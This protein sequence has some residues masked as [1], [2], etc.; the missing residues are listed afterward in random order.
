MASVETIS[1]PTGGWNARDAYA[2]MRPDHAVVLDNWFPSEG[3]VELRKGS[4]EHATTLGGWVQT[5]AE[6]HNGTTNKFLAAANNNIWDIT[7]AGAGSSLASGFTNDQWDTVMMDAKMGFVNGADAPQEYDGST[8]SAMTI[9][10]SGLTVANL[11]GVHVHGRRSYFWEDNSQDVWYSALNTLGGTLTKFQLSRVANRGGELLRMISWTRDGGDGPDDYAVF[12]MSSGE[13][14]VYRGT[15]PGNAA[16]FSI[17]GRYQIG[18]P[19]GRRCA[20]NF[21]GDVIVITKEGYVP[22]SQ[23]LGSPI[24]TAISDQISNAVK[25]HAKNHS[26]NFGWQ[27]IFFAEEGMAIFN[28]PTSSTMSVQHVFNTNTGA[29]CRFTGWNT[30]CFG[31]FQGSLYFGGNASVYQAWDGTSDDGTAIEA[32]AIPAFLP[33]GKGRITQ[34]SALQPVFISNGE[35]DVSIESR[36]DFDIGARPSTTLATG[37]AAADWDTATWDVDD[38]DTREQSQPLKTVTQEGRYL[39][40][41]MAVSTSSHEIEWFSMT[42]FY[43]VGGFL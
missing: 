36:A 34:V 42:Y 22:L 29:P 43:Q 23:R 1:A 41:R 3:Q 32:D 31:I 27:P 20:M 9:S 26:S 39:T 12:L 4:T 13:V 7:S 2:A 15:D 6:F 19:I 18:E 21:G 40:S 37:S 16:S 33:L 28:I 25:S 24:S 5:L 30:Q 35:I 8:V 38:W 14:L 17:V 10:G 11:A